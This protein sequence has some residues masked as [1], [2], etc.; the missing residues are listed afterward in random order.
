MKTKLKNQLIMHLELI[1][2]MFNQKFFTTENFPFGT[3]I[4]SWKTTKFVMGNG[5]R[6]TECYKMPFVSMISACL[7]MIFMN[8]Y[9]TPF[10]TFKKIIFYIEYA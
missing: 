3:T 5:G 1:I 9:P 2:Q 4:Q 7:H 10:W 8:L 6:I